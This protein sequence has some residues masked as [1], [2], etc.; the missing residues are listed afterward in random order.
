MFEHGHFKRIQAQKKI[1][2]AP[3]LKPPALLVTQCAQNRNRIILAT[4]PPKPRIGN[5]VNIQ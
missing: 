3:G 5:E 1:L 2:E 4:V